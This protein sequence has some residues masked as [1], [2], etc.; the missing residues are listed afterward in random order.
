[1][2]RLV[3]ARYLLPAADGAGFPRRADMMIAACFV[4]ALEPTI[5]HAESVPGMEFRALNAAGGS[6]WA[7]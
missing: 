7:S 1:M 3:V 2:K 5:A 4:I 6:R